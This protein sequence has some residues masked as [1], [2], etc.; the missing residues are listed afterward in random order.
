MDLTARVTEWKERCETALLI[1]KRLER[2]L[3]EA[4]KLEE[5]NAALRNEM[6]G[7]AEE[8][9]ELANSRVKATTALRLLELRHSTDVEILEFKVAKLEGELLFKT[10]ELARLK[11]ESGGSQLAASSEGEPASSEGERAPRGGEPA[12]SDEGN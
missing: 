1:N 8:R 2:E 11:A 5:V 6:A 4:K 9:E 10:A 12:D 3:K 7:A